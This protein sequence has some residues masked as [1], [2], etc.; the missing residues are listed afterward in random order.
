MLSVGGMSYV[1]KVK[2]THVIKPTDR[3]A[4]EAVPFQRGS[5]PDGKYVTLIT[6]HP[7]GSDQRRLVVV[8]TFHHAS[9]RAG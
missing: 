4:L 6:C 1:Y 2:G 9:K 5:M 3:R 8:G 7:K